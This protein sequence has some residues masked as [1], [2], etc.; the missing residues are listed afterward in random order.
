MT[1]EI[2][3]LSGAKKDKDLIVTN[4]SQA[5]KNPNRAN[6]YIDGEYSFSLLI[7]Q[8][9]DQKLKVGQSINLEKLKQLQK[10]S[11]YGKVYQRT[12]EWV[13]SKPRSIKETKDY[14]IKKKFT[15]QIKAKKNQDSNYYQI[16]SQDISSIISTLIDKNYL[17]DQKFVEYFLENRNLNKGISKK[18]IIQELKKK[19]IDNKIIDECLAKNIRT[20]EAEIKKIIAKKR[21]KYNKEKLIQ[22]LLRKGFDHA[23]IESVLTEDENF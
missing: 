20:D 23:L 13:L 21:D 7:T 5:I 9:S 22:L 10:L 16:S 6:V 17:N 11:G 8:L 4:I 1:L 18:Q 19:G 15:N 3:G 12:L 14:L 2:T